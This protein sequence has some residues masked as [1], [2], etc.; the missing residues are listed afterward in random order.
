M[1]ATILIILAVIYF[2][3]RIIS[4]FD[5][6]NVEEPEEDVFVEMDFTPQ[7]L[8]KFN[9][10]ED[11]K[12]FMAVRGRVFDVTRGA[13]FYGPGGPYEN[14]AGKDASRGLAKNSFD[15]ECLTPMDQPIDLLTDLTEEEIET[16]QNWEE[17]FENKYKVV[18]TLKNSD[19]IEIIVTEET[20]ENI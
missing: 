2:F 12:I 14:F 17:H 6:T 7:T 9:G 5:V 11:P 8:L 3:K 16:L 15:L 10:N 4:G 20:S 1:L 19:D 13:A 18:G